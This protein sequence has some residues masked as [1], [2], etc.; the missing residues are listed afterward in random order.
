MMPSSDCPLPQAQGSKQ[1]INVAAASGHIQNAPVLQ[2]VTRKEYDLLL[3]MI[4]TTQA[5]KYF[6]LLGR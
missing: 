5:I 3:R 6:S 1:Y 2:A 4:P